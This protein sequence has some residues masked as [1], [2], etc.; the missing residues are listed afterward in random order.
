MSLGMSPSPSELASEPPSIN[1]ELGTYPLD[2]LPLIREGG[3]T[4]PEGA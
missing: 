2:P 4:V 3:T 1:S